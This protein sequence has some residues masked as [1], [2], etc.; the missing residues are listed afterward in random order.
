MGETFKVLCDSYNPKHKFY[1][2][3]GY[4]SAPDIDFEILFSSF[5]K[6]PVGSFIDVKIVDYKDEFFIGEVEFDEFA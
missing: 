1:V 6:V 2:G 5:K 3:R 4:F